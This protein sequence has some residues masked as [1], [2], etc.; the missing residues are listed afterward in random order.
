MEGSGSFTGGYSDV[1]AFLRQG[2]AGEGFLQ[3]GHRADVAGAQLRDR[4]EG[5]PHGAADVRQSLGRAALDIR[6]GWR[7]S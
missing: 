7:R 1:Q 4:L 3:L 5:L 6:A 2:V